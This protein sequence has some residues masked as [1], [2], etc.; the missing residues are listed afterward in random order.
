M[1]R[2]SVSRAKL[3]KVVD[4]LPAILISLVIVGA[5]HTQIYANRAPS[6]SELAAYLSGG[7]QVRGGSIS[8]RGYQQVYYM[9]NGGVYYLTDGPENRRNVSISGR[10][11]AWEKE[12]NGRGQIAVHD[13]LTGTSRMVTSTGAN[14]FPRVD[15][16]GN[17]AWERWDGGVYQVIY[18]SY[19]NNSLSKISDSE[20][21]G[22]RPT[23]LGNRV[24][25]ATQ[26]ADMSWSVTEVDVVTGDRF[27]I[28]TG[29]IST[30]AWPQYQSQTELT[31]DLSQF[32]KLVEPLIQ[33]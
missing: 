29:R 14:Q 32:K 28:L 18:Y 7:G 11:I 20:R 19:Q 22:I 3:R 25:Y 16:F 9:F 6:S 33:Q 17:I 24:A 10:Y 5:Y 27:S 8:T 12:V 4:W 31:T 13:L 30:D 26:E 21:G 23:V 2:L 1:V 15:Q